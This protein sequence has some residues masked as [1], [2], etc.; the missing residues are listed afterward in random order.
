MEMIA[1]RASGQE[2]AFFYLYSSVSAINHTSKRLVVRLWIQSIISTFPRAYTRIS[3]FSRAY[4]MSFRHLGWRHIQSIIS[5]FTRAYTRIS[6]FSRAYTMSF[7]HLGWR[8]IQSIISTF[9]RAY[10]QI[11][12]LTSVHYAVPP[13]WMT[14]YP[15]HHL[16]FPTGKN[17]AI[18][19]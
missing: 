9:P 10:T 15:V 13:S 12:I 14:S 3:T 4:T 16:R 6:T 2:T 18:K 1:L 19:K 17:Y 11:N 7:R 5:T 8:H